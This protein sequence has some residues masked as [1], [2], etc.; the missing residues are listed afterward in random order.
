MI[1]TTVTLGLDP[2]VSLGLRN[3]VSPDP[4]ESPK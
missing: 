4:T 3:A 2:R 1:T